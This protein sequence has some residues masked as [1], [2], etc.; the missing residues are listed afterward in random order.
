MRRTTGHWVTVVVMGLGS[1]AAVLATACTTDDDEG[2]GAV[3]VGGE[4]SAGGAG[5][6]GGAAGDAGASALEADDAAAAELAAAEAE[7]AEVLLDT[8]ELTHAFIEDDPTL[9]LAATAAQNATAIYERI[10]TLVATACPTVTPSHSPGTAELQV[11]F[12]SCTLPG[13]LTVEGQVSVTVER[14]DVNDGLGKELVVTFTLTGVTL[15]RAEIDGTIVVS[16]QTLITYPINAEL[17]VSTLG[18]VSFDGTIAASL[19]ATVF[20]ATLD[21][22]GTLVPNT[23]LASRLPSVSFGSFTCNRAGDPAFVVTALTREL[24]QC[25]A[26][27]GTVALT[28]GYTCE[29]RQQSVT[30]TTVTTLEWD[31]NT[32]TSDT[33]TSTTVT[34]VGDESTTGEPE[35]VVLPWS[36]D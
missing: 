31:Q 16:T 4:V 20:V 35:S 17:D 19:E 25:H 29:L 15:G 34:T 27:S 3:G 24:E 5:N 21:G 7:A 1:M 12:S 23:T 13:G 33:V 26:D 2:S 22:E 32:P 14:K 28:Q 6:V 9:D 18:A 11:D 10:S 36:C 8:K 30:A